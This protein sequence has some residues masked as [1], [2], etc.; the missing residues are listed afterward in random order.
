MAV[1]AT[2]PT[3]GVVFAV[4]VHP[5]AAVTLAAIGTGG[6]V[7][8]L[9]TAHPVATSAK[10]SHALSNV[11]NPALTNAK[12]VAVSKPLVAITE[13]VIVSSSAL[14]P[15][16]R[17]TVATAVEHPVKTPVKRDHARAEVAGKNVAATTEMRPVQPH[18]ALPATSLLAAPNS[19]APATSSLTLRRVK[20]LRANVVARVY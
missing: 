6:M 18:E 3:Q 14:P 8:V 9:T 4:D 2:M 16:I 7:A 10:N 19:L 20:A 11:P 1:I 17:G 13:A 15:P 5:L 12:K